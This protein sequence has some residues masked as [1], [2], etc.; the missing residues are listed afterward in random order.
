[1]A[2]WPRCQPGGEAAKNDAAALSSTSTNAALS[3]EASHNTRSRASSAPAY[4]PPSQ[5][6]RYVTMAGSFVPASRAGRSVAGSNA[7]RKSKRSSTTSA[8]AAS[9]SRSSNRAAWTVVAVMLVVSKHA[10]LCGADTP[11]TRSSLPP[12]AEA[13]Q[14]IQPCAATRR[15]GRRAA[16]K[17]ACTEPALGSSTRTAGTHAE[18]RGD[19]AAGRWSAETAQ[20][21]NSE[22]MSR[23]K[24]E[25]AA[26]HCA[27]PL[28]LA[29]QTRGARQG[30]AATFGSRRSGTTWHPYG[31]N[32]ERC[33]AAL[34][35]RR[36]AGAERKL[37][38]KSSANTVATSRHVT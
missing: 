38:R 36:Q 23:Q 30:R 13:A 4:L 37:D 7:C 32:C 22:G 1:M 9:A 12:P 16:R 27:Q 29:T 28:L 5:L 11:P 21:S 10:L 26:R 33:G 17:A 35:L 34:W 19:G 18:R 24:P 15:V 20:G 25:R 31:L 3:S 2:P 14:A 8:P 6:G